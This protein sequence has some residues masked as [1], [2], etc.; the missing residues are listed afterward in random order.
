VEA[1]VCLA[2]LTDGASLRG[3]GLRQI[4]ALLYARIHVRVSTAFA[5]SIASISETYLRAG[6]LSQ[7]ESFRVVGA[8]RSFWAGR[9]ARTVV[10]VASL[11]VA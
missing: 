9:A 7:V 6:R 10:G 1:F 2:A 4:Q 8:A 11:G 3:P 5:T